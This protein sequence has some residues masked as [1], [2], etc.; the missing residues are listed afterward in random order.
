MTKI[1]MASTADAWLVHIPGMIRRHEIFTAEQLE[2]DTSNLEDLVTS[3][4]DLDEDCSAGHM[5]H[6]LSF[7]L[8]ADSKDTSVNAKPENSLSLI[9]REL[10][11]LASV[12]ELARAQV[13]VQT[14]GQKRDLPIVQVP[15]KRKLYPDSSENAKVDSSTGKQRQSPLSSWIGKQLLGQKIPKRYLD[16]EGNLQMMQGYPHGSL[17]IHSFGW[18]FWAKDCRSC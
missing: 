4:Q 1:V 5:D 9:Y 6:S 14:R 11:K 2:Q 17:A 15:R 12:K 18:I 13:L 3:L 10:E 16:K 8:F 7:C